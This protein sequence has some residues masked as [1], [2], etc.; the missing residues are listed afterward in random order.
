MKYYILILAICLISCKNDNNKETKKDE[1]EIVDTK[2]AV[3]AD[4]N[5]FKI[6]LN[7][8]VEK[9]DIFEVYYTSDSVEEKFSAK[10]KVRKK[11]TG[12]SQVQEVVF[13]LP[14][15][16]LPYNFRI[17]LGQNKELSSLMIHHIKLELNGEFIDIDQSLIKSFFAFNQF[18]E[19]ENGHFSLKEVKGKWDPFMISK[20]VLIKKIE[21]EL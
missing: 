12:N 7:L 8:T 21:I 19:H 5:I 1:Q 3:V 15:D 13:E 4:E 17:D 10:K 18:I 14:V 16:V 20:A 9:D 6:H 11:I 2:E